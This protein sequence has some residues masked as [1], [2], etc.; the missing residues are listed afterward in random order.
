MNAPQDDISDRILAKILGQELRQL[1]EAKGWSRVDLV[2]RLPSRI[3]DR[4]LLSYEHGVRGLSVN[5]LIE[6]CRVLGV[7]AGEFLDRVVE[8]ARDLRAF[9]F[10]VD[11]RAVLRDQ[12]AEFESVRFWATT[13]LDEGDTSVTLAPVTVREMAAVLGISHTTLAA[14]LVEFTA[15]DA[16]P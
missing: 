1:R 12:R 8:K 6:I 15:E 5:R 14:Y 4:T 9:S 13:R 16:P 3:G 7:G 2:R 10:R 11:L